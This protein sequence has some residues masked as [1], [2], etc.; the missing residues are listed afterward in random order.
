[1]AA[2]LMKIPLQSLWMMWENVFDLITR[3]RS[4]SVLRYGI[5]KLVVRQ[6][7]GKRIACQDGHGIQAGDWV[8]ELHLDNRQVMGL[9]RTFGADRAGL[10]TVR[11]L[12]D[13]MKQISKELDSNTDLSEVRAITGITLLHRG[14]THGIGFEQHP[15]ESRWQQRFYAAYLR[16]LLRILHPEGKERVQYSSEKLAPLMLVISKQSLKERFALRDNDLQA[17][18]TPRKKEAI[19]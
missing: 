15:I 10:K 12:R 14:I 16:L 19:S 17:R 5:C 9:S 1:M 6:H 4:K 11:M 7:H 8:G 13:A 2:S 3:F 18:H